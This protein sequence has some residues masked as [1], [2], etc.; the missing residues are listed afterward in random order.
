MSILPVDTGTLKK[1]RKKTELLV[2]FTIAT[3]IPASG[4]VRILFPSTVL[5]DPQCRSAITKGSTLVSSTGTIA[6]EVQSNSWY[7][8]NFDAL[9][10]PPKNVVI[11]GTATLPTSSGAT[12]NFGIYT[13][14]NQDA[15]IATNGQVLDSSAAA[16][17]LTIDAESTMGIDTSLTSYYPSIIRAQSNNFH[18]FIFDFTP[19]AV[20]ITTTGYVQIRVPNSAFSRATLPT[21]GVL[22]CYFLQLP[23]NIKLACKVS[24]STTGSY[25][26]YSL[27]PTTTLAINTKYRGVITTKFAD[28]GNDGIMFPSTAKVYDIIY[29]GNDGTTATEKNSFP[30]E[31]YPSAFSSLSF[32]SYI[33]EMSTESLV[34][35]TISA[36]STNKIATT[37]TITIEIPVKQNSTDMFDEDLGLGLYDRANKNCEQLSSSP[38]A[39]CKIL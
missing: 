14:G 10:P 5:P 32:R 38:A 3:A 25:D 22:Y 2:S 19:K 7:I 21:N 33:V 11:Y 12:S 28:A 20:T 4:S 39:T 9:G 15:D 16:G 36:L 13:Y 37:D 24:T 34:E 6:C 18:P 27:V 8:T 1:S 35:V 17:V 23:D 31:V 26:Q 29:I 30:L